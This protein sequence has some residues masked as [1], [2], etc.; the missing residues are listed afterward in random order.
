MRKRR[1][2]VEW[3]TKASPDGLDRLGQMVRLVIEHAVAPVS[4]GMVPE[5]TLLPHGGKGGQDELGTDEDGHH[6]G[7]D[8]GLD[9]E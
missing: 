6:G 5:E 7:R 9:V 2:Q 3:R 4:R 1:W 8:A